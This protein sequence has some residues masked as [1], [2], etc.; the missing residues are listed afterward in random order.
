MDENK[1]LDQVRKRTDVPLLILFLAVLALTMVYSGPVSA[2][3]ARPIILIFESSMITMF[4]MRHNWVRAVL[5]GLFA[6]GAL[7]LII[8]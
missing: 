1:Y 6:L 8:G 4:V 2:F 7:G 3:W 5:F